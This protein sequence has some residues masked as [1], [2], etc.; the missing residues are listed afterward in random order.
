[1][2]SFSAAEF[3]D[4]AKKMGQASEITAAGKPMSRGAAELMY[5][6]LRQDLSHEQVSAGI[7]GHLNSTGGRFMPTIAD[8]RKQVGGTEEERGLLAWRFFRRIFERW[9]LYD[10]VKFPHPAYHYAIEQLGGWTRIGREWHDFTE[11]EMEFR[12]KDFIRLYL[13]GERVASWH[14]EDGKVRVRPYLAGSIELE[15]IS[16]GF[17]HYA[18]PDVIDVATGKKIERRELPSVFTEALPGGVEQIGALENAR[19]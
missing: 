16:R 9:S 14:T 8:I 1:M 15:N 13:V 2:S 6:L 7:T 18:I 11:K 3:A 12:S 4:F 5:G 10:S 17:V 19:I